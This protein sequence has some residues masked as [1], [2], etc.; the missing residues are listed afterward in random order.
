MQKLK[1]SKNWNN[2]LGCE[3]FTTIRLH[4]DHLKRN[5]QRE[6]ELKG[7]VIGTIEIYDRIT[8]TLA[9]IPNTTTTIDAGLIRPDFIGMMKK[10]YSKYNL[11]WETQ[12]LDILFCK[13]I[14][15]KKEVKP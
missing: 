8:L 9:E 7:L 6:V 14:S 3:Y 5:E 11:N 4:N 12:K 2:K 1:F 15:R 13:F 10:M